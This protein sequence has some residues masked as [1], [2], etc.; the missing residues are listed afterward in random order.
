MSTFV[1][2][3]LISLDGHD[4]N[5][6][7]APEPEEHLEFNRLFGDADLIL[8]D[9]PDYELLVP[10][11]DVLDLDDPEVDDIEREFALMFR[12]KPRLVVAPDLEEVDAQAELI[13]TDPIPHL[14]ALKQ[15]E[16]G[17]VLVSAGADLLT[18]LFA[19]QLIDELHVVM[20]PCLIGGTQSSLSGLLCTIPLRL[21][22]TRALDS[23]TLVLRYQVEGSTKD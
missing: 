13:R 14:T 23:G 22:E 15:E 7:A 10:A 21:L 11:W 9:Q 18:T 19:H 3:L 12:T 16:R 20:R 5:D 17:T 8:F 2:S 1:A 6:I 4:A